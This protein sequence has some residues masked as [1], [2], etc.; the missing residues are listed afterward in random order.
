MIKVLKAF[1]NKFL[2][3]TVVFLAFMLFFDKN[4][5]FTQFERKQELQE[6]QQK[7]AFYEQEITATKDKLTE[8]QT[9]PA[10]L[11]KFS[12]EEYFMKRDD[13]VIYVLEN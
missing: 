13:E 12:R 4:D 6:L 7:K 8:L 10:A 11:E 5:V 1:S 3:A 9:N 2:M